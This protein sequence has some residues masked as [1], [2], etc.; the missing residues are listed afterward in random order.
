[1]NGVQFREDFVDVLWP[2][3]GLG[4]DPFVDRAHGTS[5]RPV[6]HRDGQHMVAVSSRADHPVGASCRVS[7]LGV[8]VADGLVDGGCPMFT[9]V[10]VVNRGE[11]ALR[12]TR[13][14]RELNEQRG[15]DIRVIVLHT[16]AERRALFVR[17]AD[18][19]VSLRDI[20]ERERRLPRPHRAR[21][22]TA[23]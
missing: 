11:P 15:Y 22:G 19:A 14:V 13:A 10:V 6:D 17:R 21:T 4:P 12:L 1:M 20:T 8:P 7:R 16:R 5:L 2:C 18:E 9:R 23:R 3:L